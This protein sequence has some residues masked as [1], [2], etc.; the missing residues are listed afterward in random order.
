MK[1]GEGMKIVS[2][3]FHHERVC[4]VLQS[5][6]SLETDYRKTIRYYVCLHKPLWYCKII[7]KGVKVAKKD[8]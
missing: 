5:S 8:S 7:L 3:S 4:N 6:A 2:Y 1:V